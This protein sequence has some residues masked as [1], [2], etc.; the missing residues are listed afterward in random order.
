VAS[1]GARQPRRRSR[2]IH[3]PARWRASL[4]S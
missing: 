3:I 1:L 4:R 2:A